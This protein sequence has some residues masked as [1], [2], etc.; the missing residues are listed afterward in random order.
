MTKAPQKIQRVYGICWFAREDYDT[1]RALMSDPEALFDT[2]D[3]WLSAARKLE[4]QVALEGDKSVRIR[5][6]RDSFLL[7]CATHN[8]PP[9]EQA[10]ANWAGQEVKKK[11]TQAG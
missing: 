8:L 4:G 10:R 11:Y 9:Y 6:D 7:Y 1:A 2:Y 3:E 5:F